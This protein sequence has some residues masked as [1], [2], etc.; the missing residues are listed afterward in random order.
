VIDK[1]MG[2]L[3]ALRGIAALVVVLFHLSP[4]VLGAPRHLAVA[5]HLDFGKYAV[6]LFFLV[7]GYVIPMSLERHGSLRR[8]WTGRVCRIY[9]AFLAAI[10]LTAAL[11]ALRV[12]PPPP[13][14]PGE[15]PA[16]VLAHAA[17]MQDPLG[18]RAVVPVFW[19]L[20]YEMIF[21]L[22]VS[23]L[24]A[25]RLHR[26]SAWWA[27]GL[28][29]VALLAGGV[30]PDGLLTP[31]PA[32][33]GIAAVV[34]LAVVAGSILAY[35]SG[36]RAAALAAGA[37]GMALVLLP[38]LNGHPTGFSTAQASW[39]GLLLLA[40][41]F[42]GTVLYR[43]H[44]GQIGRWPAAA[45][46][47]TVGVS[48]VVT[49]A[50]QLGTDAARDGWIATTA[51]VAGTF[52]LGYGLRARPVPRP[53]LWLGRISYS[54][55]VL[56]FVVLRV[57]AVQVPRAWTR[58]PPER[59][60]FGVAYLAGTLALGWLSYRWVEVP[61]QALGRRLLAR[62]WTRVPTARPAQEDALI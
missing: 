22:I 51:A 1:R 16:I 46:L 48:L 55:Y 17:L 7:S 62:R 40:V 19:T 58:P 4:S 21:Y 54:V 24:F 15:L 36:R 57:L 9:P 11:T 47:L 2:W 56:H 60:W 26:G 38:A 29:L 28:A 27:A 6:L 59:I 10:A 32:G 8:F 18:E 3:D 35:L 44:Y 37:A 25:W 45:A 52:A 12:L 14:P 43:A 61:G 30:L 34:L 53:L 31:G 49:H 33:R 20:S 50:A 23:G 39:Q 42:A 41:M 13:N 5:A